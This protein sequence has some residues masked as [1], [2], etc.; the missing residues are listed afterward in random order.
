M[1]RVAFTLGPLAGRGQAKTTLKLLDLRGFPHIPLATQ[2][3]SCMSLRTCHILTVAEVVC[4]IRPK[5]PTPQPTIA[6]PEL[7]ANTVSIEQDRYSSAALTH[8]GLIKPRCAGASDLALVATARAARSQPCWPQ[9][10]KLEQ[11]LST[12]F[13]SESSPTPSA[14][15]PETLLQDRYRIVRQL[16]KG[17]MGAVYEAIDQRLS[18]SV[19]IKET[20][21][22]DHRLRKQFEREACLLAQLNHPALPRVSDYFNERNRAFLVMQFISGVDLAQIIVQQPGPFPLE[23]VI[24]WADQLLDALIYLHTCDR[25]IIHRDIKP[26]NL[27]LTASGQIALLDFGLAKAEAPDSQGAETASSFFGFTPRYAPLEQIQDEGTSPQSD[28]YAL[29]ATL[30]QLFTGVKPSDALTRA[31]AVVN[32]QPDP[33]TPA[34]QLHGAVSPELAAILNRAMAQNPEERYASASEFREA[35]RRLGRSEAIAETN[36]SGNE[37]WRRRP[38]ISE[39]SSTLRALETADSQSSGPHVIA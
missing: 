27:K 20:F 15:A 13:D 35:L 14:L 28:I 32:S 29:G 3:S 37:I 18:V 25:Q 19:A 12:S 2:H 6:C 5:A 10:S 1:P 9:Q 24:A 31:A 17:G 39:V 8:Q 4:W 16:G 36:S 7:L 11:P 30:Y 26:H 22:R 21:S 23:Q 33:L 38:T 34:N